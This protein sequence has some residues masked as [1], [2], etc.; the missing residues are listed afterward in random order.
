MYRK[1][2][3]KHS[4]DALL[5][6]GFYVYNIAEGQGQSMQVYLLPI[7]KMPH[8]IL[9]FQSLT[10]GHGQRMEYKPRKHPISED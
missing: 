5:G 9:I 6:Q 2:L 3:G 7:I 10:K 4:F 8:L 1:K